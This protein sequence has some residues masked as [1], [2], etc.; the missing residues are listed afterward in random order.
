MYQA[1][2]SN[3][4]RGRFLLTRTR[5]D[6]DDAID[7]IQAAVKAIPENHPDRAVMLSNLGSVLQARFEQTGGKAD[8]DDAIDTT[9]AAAS[10]TPEDHPA[11]AVIVANL[12][13]A[14]RTRFEFA[15]GAADQQAALSYFS[16]VADLAT[17]TPTVR[18]QAAREVAALCSHSEPHRAADMLEMAI[19]LLGEVAPR[20]L[21]R[22]DQQYTIS[23]LAGLAGDAAALAVTEPGATSPAKAER[24]LRLLEA[25]RAVLLS[26]ALATRDDLTDLRQHHPDLEVC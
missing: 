13:A 24:A 6:L 2:L 12:G 20:H 7:T 15:R 1:N 22:G 21:K 5:S 3:A 17:A 18:I 19:G 10:I 26:Q 16:Q 23:R 11:R 4:L 14:F 9:Q 8:L 25:G